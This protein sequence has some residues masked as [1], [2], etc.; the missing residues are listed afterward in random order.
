MERKVRIH[1]QS[2]ERLKYQKEW[3]Y[4]EQAKEVRDLLPLIKSKGLRLQ[5]SYK[6][7]L[8]GN[9]QIDGDRGMQA[10]LKAFLEE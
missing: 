7:S 10:A 6:D 4:N 5:L 1:W 3:R 2:D 8:V 9:I